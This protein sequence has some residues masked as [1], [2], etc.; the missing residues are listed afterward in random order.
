MSGCFPT[1]RLGEWIYDSINYI[2]LTPE[3]EP[4]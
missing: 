1:V 3:G 2:C 4:Q